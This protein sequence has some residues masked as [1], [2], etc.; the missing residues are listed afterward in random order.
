VGLHRDQL[1]PIVPSLTDGGG[2]TAS[3][4]RATGLTAGT[5]VVVG[6]TDTAA[7]LVSVGAWETG[8]SLVK[9]AST[10]TVVGITPEPVVDRRLL[11]YP[12]AL[13]GRWYTLGATNTAAVAYAWLRETMF[14]AAPASPPATYAEMDRSASRVPAGSAGIMF[15]PFLQGERTPYWDADLRAAF[16]GV[17]SGHDR[18]H[19]AR[20]VL[21]GVALALRACR[22][23]MNEVGIA[24]ER[25]V[26]AGGGATSRLWRTILVSMLE[27][28][29][30]L[31][32]PQGP[33]VGAAMLAA[34]M[35][36]ATPGAAL[37]DF[38]PRRTVRVEPRE[39]WVAAYDALYEIHGLAVASVAEVSHRLVALAR[40][41]DVGG[42]MT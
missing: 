28:V 25:P 38:R 4:A 2:L 8:D 21:E 5:P 17:S 33:A 35:G 20:A 27:Q 40:G 42:G 16:L 3:W 7:E 22:D 12:H 1:P 30:R 41:P 39:D 37:R 34:A 15:L 14:A 26:L 24:T 18:D 6:A 23:V 11:T 19:M 31:I 13:P 9:I 10:G 32:E 29:G 36:H